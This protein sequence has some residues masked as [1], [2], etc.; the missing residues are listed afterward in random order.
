MVGRAR[1]RRTGQTLGERMREVRRGWAPDL[2]LEGLAVV[3]ALWPLWLRML[4]AQVSG[5]CPPSLSALGSRG[6]CVQRSS[7]AAA[8]GA[9]PP[10]VRAGCASATSLPVPCERPAQ[11]MP[12]SAAWRLGP[13]EAK[14]AEAS[15]GRR[16][17]GRLPTGGRSRSRGRRR[18]GGG[19]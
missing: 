2:C 13:E 4:G 1:P 14:V 12:S 19:G 8:P 17:A 5:I 7:T 9:V 10:A 18:P 15:T 11:G 6:R 16:G 3:S